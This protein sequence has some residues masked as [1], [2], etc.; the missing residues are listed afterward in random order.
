MKSGRNFRPGYYF[1]GRFVSEQ[2]DAQ[3]IFQGRVR[4]IVL[5]KERK[6][7]KKERERARSR[8]SATRQGMRYE[9]SLNKSSSSFNALPL[10][11][12]PTPVSTNLSPGVHPV[13]PI[14][15]GR[16]LQNNRCTIR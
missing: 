2:G 3:I 10:L 5:K 14:H 7:K 9:Y 15:L 8:K 16:Q 11:Y 12:Y 13:G 4:A 1:H 6:K